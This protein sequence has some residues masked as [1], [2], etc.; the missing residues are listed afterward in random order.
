MS[1][2]P[3]RVTEQD[4]F[5]KQKPTN[6]TNK[7]D[8]KPIN[9]KTYIYFTGCITEV[10]GLSVSGWLLLTSLSLEMSSL[11]FREPL[12]LRACKSVRTH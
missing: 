12:G 2:R 9:L 4:S 3:V 6:L 7:A 11:C 1:L 10:L 8:E 5:L